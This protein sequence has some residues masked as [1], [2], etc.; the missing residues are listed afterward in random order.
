MSFAYDPTLPA[1][2]SLISALELRTQMIGLQG[3]SDM[4]YNN[5][6]ARAIKPVGVDDLL[7]PHDLR[8]ADAGGGDRDSR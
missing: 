2:G 4:A 5:A 7:Q 6:E 1:D 8:P 3:L